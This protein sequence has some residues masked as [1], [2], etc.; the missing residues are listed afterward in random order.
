M[1]V[2]K[3]AFITIKKPAITGRLFCFFK[4]ISDVLLVRNRND[5]G[6]VVRADDH[7][8]GHRCN[9]DRYRKWA[10]RRRDLIRLNGNIDRPDPSACFYGYCWRQLKRR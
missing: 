4:C 6:M 10:T 5:F 8:A 7:I 1:T 9:T 3:V 2:C